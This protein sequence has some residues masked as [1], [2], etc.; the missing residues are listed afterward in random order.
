MFR[1]WGRGFG[2]SLTALH[3]LSQAAL[4]NRIPSPPHLFQPFPPPPHPE[5]PPRWPNSSSAGTAYQLLHGCTWVDESACASLV[6]QT[7]LTA[8]FHPQSV[9]DKFNVM[10]IL[11]CCNTVL[12]RPTLENCLETP[13][14]N[15]APV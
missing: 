15:L 4:P 7:C 8:C 2:C 12:H 11:D 1:T 5:K 3:P 10:S 6:V 13:V 9:N 14:R